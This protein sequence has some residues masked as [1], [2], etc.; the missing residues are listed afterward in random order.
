MKYLSFA[1]I[2]FRGRLIFACANAKSM[3]TLQTGD[4]VL[5]DEHP[6]SCCFRTFTSCIKSCTKSR[7]SHCAIVLKDYPV[8]GLFVWESSWHPDNP[9]AD[10]SDHRVHKFG[11]QITPLSFYLSGYPGS[12]QVFVRR[13]KS[14]ATIAKDT[15]D[16]IY[17]Q[18]LDKPYDIWPC[19]WVAAKLRCRPRRT[20]RGSG[21]VPLHTFWCR[22]KPSRPIATGAWSGHKTCRLPAHAH[23]FRGRQSMRMMYRW[24]EYELTNSFIH[25]VHDKNR[26]RF[27]IL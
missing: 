5:V 10:P 4:I 19:D 26:K 17:R 22:P 13:R 21:A 11:V 16:I 6:S 1:P 25:I 23:P 20:Q 27:L 24:K 18:T 9:L 8:P 2:A 12:A 14:P 7:Y 3:E 15:L